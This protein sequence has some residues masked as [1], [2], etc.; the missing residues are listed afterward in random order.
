ML[1][2]FEWKVYIPCYLLCNNGMHE[3][4]ALSLIW[5]LDSSFVRVELKCIDISWEMYMQYACYDTLLIL[6][7]T[8][9]LAAIIYIV[10]HISIEIQFVAIYYCYFCYYI[11]HL[12]GKVQW[13]IAKKRGEGGGGGWESTYSNTFKVS[14]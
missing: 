5:L 6:F 1:W 11:C 10:H 8:S 12:V 13:R 3:L 9:S 2:I 7:Y 4:C 14:F